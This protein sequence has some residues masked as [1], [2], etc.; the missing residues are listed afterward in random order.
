MGRIRYNVS[1]PSSVSRN[2]IIFFL[3]VQIAQLC[4]FFLCANSNSVTVPPC[5]ERERQALLEFKAS[6]IKVPAKR[7]SSWKDS[8]TNCCEWEGIGCDNVTGHVVKLDLRNPCFKLAAEVEEGKEFSLPYGCDYGF[9]FNSNENGVELK[10]SIQAPNVSQSLLRLDHLTYLDLTGNNFSSSPI[11]DSI[12]NS[13]GRLR[14]LSLSHANFGGKIPSSL[15]N[16]K[17]LHHLDLQGRM[18]IGQGSNSDLQSNDITWISQIQSLRR[19]DMSDV[20]LGDADAHNLFQVL[21]MLPSLSSVYLS[22][23][24]LNNSLVPVNATQNMTSLVHLDLSYNFLVSVPPWFSLNLVYV[25]LSRNH[26]DSVP[27]WFRSLKLVYLDLSSN[28]LHGPIFEAFRNMTSLVHLDLSYNDLDLIPSWFSGLK[29]V[30][31]DLSRTG[32]HGPIPE[33]F[34]NMTSIQTLYLG[35]NNFT[36]IPSWFVELKTLLELDLSYNELI[37]KK[38]PLSSILSNM[39]HLKRLYFSRNKLREEPIASY[40]LSGCIRYD[41]E[42]LD[43]SHNEFSDRLPTWL[44]KL[45]NLEWLDLGS[46]SFFGPIPLS[47]GKL[48]KLESLDLSYNKLDGPLPYSIGRLVNLQTLDLSC[49]S[50]NVHLEYLNLSSNKFYGSVPQSL[51]EHVSLHT[52]DLSLNNLSGEVPNCWKDNQRWTEINFASNKLSGVFPISLGNLSSLLWL[53]LRDNNLHGKLPMPLRNLKNLLILD[54]GEN[55]LSGSIPSSWIGNTFPSLHILILRQN[56]LSGSI[57]NQLCQLTSLKVLDLSLNRLQ[58]SIPLCIGNL[59]GMALDKSPDKANGK[60][61]SKI[62]YES[63]IED[64]E[65]SDEDITQV[66]KG[67][68]VH[69][70]QITKLVVNM[71]LSSNN[72]VGTIPNGITLITG[73]HFL[74]LSNN[75]LKGEIPSMIGNMKELESL[76]VSHNQIYGTIPNSMPALTSFSSLNLSHNNLSGPI[77]QKY[78]FLTFNDPSIYAD[79]PYLCGP[80]LLNKCHDDVSHEAPESKGN[81]DEDGNKDEVENIWFYFVIAAGFATGFWGVI[82]TLLFKKNLR[83]AYFRWVEVVADKIYVASVLKVAKLKKHTMRNQAHG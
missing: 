52:L 80:P 50:F 24:G 26:L 78:Q 22:R 7:I 55:K 12:G 49:N 34:R 1:V 6:L 25:Q 4:C 74:N 5:I 83:H 32:L 64:S 16:L 18:Y 31:L 38:Y 63:F 57:P 58:G 9:K 29:L 72:L 47:I 15:R 67:I 65:W 39:C 11:P 10:F 77:P 13:M 44:G 46:N 40:Q 42:E 76:D 62:P 56:M 75:H 36:S 37:P 19:L 79:N 35:Q 23:C 71:D 73:L 43:L 61:I 59:T 48:S 53:H 41:L 81:E 54:L 68:E 66:I 30:Y 27:S 70:K 82:G 69:Y 33:A 51:G 28:V 20:Y 3:L 21:T 45:E 8:S 14:Y 2:K 60:W 17:N